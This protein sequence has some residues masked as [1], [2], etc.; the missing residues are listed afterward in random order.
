MDGDSS[1]G[2]FTD[3]QEALHD[4]VTGRAAIHE[5]EVVM[6]EAGICEALCIVDFLIQ[7]DYGRH[8]VF[9]EVREVGFWCMKRVS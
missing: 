5:E 8:V 3:M 6:L 1:L 7:A 4:G 2:A 9:P